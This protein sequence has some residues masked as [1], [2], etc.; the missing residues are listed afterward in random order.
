MKINN[1]TKEI[2]TNDIDLKI[3]RSLLISSYSLTDLAKEVG[4]AYKNLLPHIKKLES[5]GWLETKKDK[6]SRGQRVI[7]SSKRKDIEGRGLV[8]SKWRDIFRGKIGEKAEIEILKVVKELDKKA[9]IE[10]ITYLTDM[11]T[12]NVWKRLL[13]GLLNKG[14]VQA[15]F[16][17]TKEGEEFLG[18]EF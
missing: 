15:K 13:E 1:K 4:I 5:E 3:L 8:D 10:A 12:K 17:I 7:V 2:M 11:D 6:E 9:T 14:Y 18:E 16:E